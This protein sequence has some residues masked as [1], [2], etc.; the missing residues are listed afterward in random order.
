M[1]PA[2]ILNSR[3]LTMLVIAI[4]AALLGAF[5]LKNEGAKK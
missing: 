1:A 3:R 5:N 4:F 2:H